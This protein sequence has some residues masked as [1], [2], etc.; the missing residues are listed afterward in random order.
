[1]S[2]GNKKLWNDLGQPSVL[3]FKAMLGISG[4]DL[5]CGFH[6]CSIGCLVSHVDPCDLEKYDHANVL[7]RLHER[8]AGKG[9]KSG[10]NYRYH[11]PRQI[12]E[13]AKELDPCACPD[14]TG[15]CPQHDDEEGEETKHVVEQGEHTDMLAAP[16]NLSGQVG[17]DERILSFHTLSELGEF[18]HL[19]QRFDRFGDGVKDAKCDT[20][21]KEEEE[22]A[23]VDEEGEEQGEGG[24]KQD[25][26]ESENE[27]EEVEEV[28]D[29]QPERKRR[30]LRHNSL[31]RRQNLTGPRHQL[32]WP[33][34]TVP[35][36][37]PDGYKRSRVTC[38]LCTR[39]AVGKSWRTLERDDL[40]CLGRAEAPQ[41]ARMRSR[42]KTGDERAK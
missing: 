28:D 37:L 24:E 27:E 4:C 40:S 19:S 35:P 29:R 23:N 41:Q 3:A 6:L 13:F 15:D 2:D 12:F 1:M 5:D 8:L 18:G 9:V 39:S 22:E 16:S 31:L 30:R 36:H 20:A 34:G 17:D 11:M 32:E 10:H 25:T 7:Q 14:S 26:D 42:A 33:D 21:E 38:R